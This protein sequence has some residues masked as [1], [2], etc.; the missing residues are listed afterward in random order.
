MKYF[1]N[2]TTLLILFVFSNCSEKMQPEIDFTPP[3]YVQELPAREDDLSEPNQGSLFGRGKNPLFSD[4]KAMQVNDVLT[5]VISE[6]TSASSTTQKNLAKVNEG[7]LGGGLFTGSMVESLN[8]TTNV[9]LETTSE[10]SYSGSGT[11]IRDESFETTITARVI[12]ILNNGNY[13]IDGSRELL[14][15]GEKQIIQVSGVI[16]PYNISAN[17]EIESKYI[18]DAKVQYTTQGELDQG[19]KRGW[20]SRFLDTIWPF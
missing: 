14:I 5:V 8:D 7:A 9:A 18:S 16:S 12:K 1:L 3:T 4:R 10:S 6:A 11:A 2:I 13:F 19:T 20:L 15:N 17:N